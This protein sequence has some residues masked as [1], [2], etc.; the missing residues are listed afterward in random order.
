MTTMEKPLDSCCSRAGEN[1]TPVVTPKFHL[2]HLHRKAC[3][4]SDSAVDMSSRS[5]RRQSMH[6]QMEQQRENLECNNASTLPPPK[7]IRGRVGG[8]STWLLLQAFRYWGFWE[9]GACGEARG[10]RRICPCT[11]GRKLQPFFLLTKF[12]QK[13]KLKIKILKKKWFS[14]FSVAKTE[15]KN[16]HIYI[17]G[18]YCQCNQKYRKY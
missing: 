11:S 4:R 17:P 15:K 9:H 7:L 5:S 1:N 18:F 8:A 2:L 13:A 3:A 6:P 10:D 16:R 12:R 14:R